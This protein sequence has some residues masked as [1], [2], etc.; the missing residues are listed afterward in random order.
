MFQNYQI[1]DM[2][3]QHHIMEAGEGF[4][5][6]IPPCICHQGLTEKAEPFSVVA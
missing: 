4:M 3:H 1:Q 6:S 5:G 2:V